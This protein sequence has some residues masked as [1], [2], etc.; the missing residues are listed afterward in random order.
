MS[1]RVL[2]GDC[3]EVL[4]SLPAGS[5]QCVVTSPPYFGLRD[6]GVAGQIGLERT[7]N[8][9][10]ATL[11]AVFSEVRRVLRDDGSLWLNLGDSFVR[12]PEKGGSGPGGKN[13]EYG[14]T[15]TLA[16]SARV[17]SSDGAV[18]RADRPGSRAIGD[19]LKPKD[20]IGIPWRVAFALQADGWY[21]RQ[22]NIWA[23]PNG[24]P[25]SVRDR[26]TS[27][28]EYVFHL[29]KSERYVYDADAART[30]AAPA[31]ETRL[32]QNVEAQEGSERA[33]GGAK[34]NGR[35]KAVQR[36]DKQRGHVRVHAG[37]NDRWDAM[38]KAE[39]V[40]GGSNLRSVWWISPAQFR[41]AHFAVMPPRL[42]EICITAGSRKGDT[43]LDPFG[44]AG[45]T[46][47][48]ADRLGRDAV[49]I[50]LNPQYAEMAR[51]RVRDDS[52]LFTDVA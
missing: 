27:S 29:A 41:E 32:A 47:L 12:A 24:M 45:T 52:P 38:E 10:V 18:G 51:C 4:A 44:G 3:R 49:L 8:D 46:G 48:V 21:L 31:T 20:L 11:V 2:E 37:F 5:V 17:G 25:E 28:H 36:T 22:C 6:Y 19:G 40:A 33:N 39:Q 23:K 26:S 14:Q 43:I 42:A 34:T 9:Y 1:V 15:Y 35:M 7:V 16:Q 30:P 50:E 13:G